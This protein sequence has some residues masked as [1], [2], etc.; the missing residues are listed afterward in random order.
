[1]HAGKKKKVP[2]TVGQDMEQ[3]MKQMD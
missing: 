3:R 2:I 1:M